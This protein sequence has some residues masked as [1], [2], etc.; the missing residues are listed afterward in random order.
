MSLAETLAFLRASGTAF[1]GAMG[2]SIGET[3]PSPK[4]RIRAIGLR[5]NSFAFFPET[6]TK[7]E[8]PSFNVDA[9]AA[10][11]TPS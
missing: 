6:K 8:A 5:F 4:P 7:A 11:I 1:D 2:N 3:A 10:V 9:F